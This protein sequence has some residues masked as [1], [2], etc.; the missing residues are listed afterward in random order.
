MYHP[1][2][3]ARRRGVLLRALAFAGSLPSAAG[4]ATYYVSPSGSDANP[5]SITLP[6]REIRR[7]L[8]FVGAGD[9]ILAADG[10]YKGFDVNDLHGAAGAP[11]T[12]R[13]QG[14]GAVV[15]VTNDRPDNRDTIFITF[16]SYIVVDG[17]RA[18]GAIRAGVRV[19]QSPRVTVRNG[20]FGNNTTWGIFTDFSDDLLIENNECYG[21]VQE[22]G[23]YVSNSGDRA[24]VR[25]NRLHDNNAAGVQLNADASAGGDGIITN[26]LIENNVAY[27]NGVAGGAAINLDGVQDSVVR[28][29]LLYDNHATGIVNYMGDGAEGP[30]GMRIL[31]NTVD[32]A[33][34][35]RWAL[36]MFNTSGPNFVR[37]NILYN[38]NPSRGGITYL[39]PIDVT[40][41]DSDYNIMDRVTPDDGNM[42][43]TLAQWQAR[44]VADLLGSSDRGLVV[45]LVVVETTGDVRTDVPLHAI[46]GQHRQQTGDPSHSRRRAL[47]NDECDVGER[48]DRRQ[49]SDGVEQE[50]R[51]ARKRCAVPLTAPDHVQACISQ[52]C[53]SQACIS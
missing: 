27:R 41:T 17:L 13:A 10:T 16:S 21:S 11:I 38:R 12:I 15:L 6:C 22:H 50:N 14:T 44:Y 20:V 30:R 26:A 45:E 7:P 24:V 37:N 34:D 48:V 33:A 18:F 51:A 25:G 29:N 28:N 19:D 42:V 9:T 31:H 46:G 43:Y 4:A 3:S 2:V 35:A 49:F 23:I 32:Q 5:C 39:D 36:L 47:K 1:P 52:A 8:T 53:I 40:N